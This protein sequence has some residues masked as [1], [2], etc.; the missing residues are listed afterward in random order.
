MDIRIDRDYFVASGNAG[1]LLTLTHE[2][3]HALGFD[4]SEHRTSVMHAESAPG[5]TMDSEAAQLPDL[6]GP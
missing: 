5:A 1:P 3:V 4:H 2:M 6:V